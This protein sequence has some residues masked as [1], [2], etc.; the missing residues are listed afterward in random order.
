MFCKKCGKEVPEDAKFCVYC[1]YEFVKEKDSNT[2][3]NTLCPNCRAEL[4]GG[5]FFCTKCGTKMRASKINRGEEEIKGLIRTERI[6]HGDFYDLYFTPSQVIVAK[7]GG[8][9]GWIFALGAIIGPIVAQRE[10]AKKSDKLNKLSAEGILNANKRNFAI[11]YGEITR[12]HV[13]KNRTL[14]ITTSNNNYKYYILMNRKERIDTYIS[15]L[16]SILPDKLSI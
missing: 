2:I 6:W 9:N 4:A 10:A 5:A 3:T 8:S 7:T 14:Y 15:L 1:G 12:I 13:G 11:L 16:H